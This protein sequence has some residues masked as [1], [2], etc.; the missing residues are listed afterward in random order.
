M[1]EEGRENKG[2]GKARPLTN[3]D[4]EEDCTL[5][6]THCKIRTLLVALNWMCSGRL[7]K[8]IINFP[9]ATEIHI[10]RICVLLALG[11]HRADSPLTCSEC[12]CHDD[13]KDYDLYST[14]QRTSHRSMKGVRRNMDCRLIRAR[15]DS[16][17]GMHVI[18]QKSRFDTTKQGIQD[19]A[20]WQ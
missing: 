19:D 9:R 11:N 1:A 12:E 13:D 16:T 14:C 7:N 18:C 15:K 4:N 6:R 20:D 2:P 10:R 8:K 17:H 3:V 5:F